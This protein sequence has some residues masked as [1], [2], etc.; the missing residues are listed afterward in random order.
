MSELATHIIGFLLCGIC[1][2]IFLASLSLHK[3]AVYCLLNRQPLEGIIFFIVG[4]SVDV[5]S[6]FV[7][8]LGYALMGFSA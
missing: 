6:F 3:E 1:M 2:S 4:L 8:I 5:V 7:F